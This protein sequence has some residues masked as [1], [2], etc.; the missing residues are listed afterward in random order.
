M[1]KRSRVLLIIF[2]LCSAKSAWATPAANIKLAYDFKKGELLLEADHV[3][4][5][6]QNHYIHTMTIYENNEAPQLIYFTRQ[7]KPSKFT[8]DVPL[9][10]QPGDAIRVVLQCIKGGTSEETLVVPVAPG[11]PPIK[12]SH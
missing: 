9:A 10:V 11:Q 2:L 12:K 7:A 4:N 5:S 3:S 8:A 6:L 1:K